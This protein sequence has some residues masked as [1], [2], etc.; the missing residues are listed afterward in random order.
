MKNYC[1]KHQLNHGAKYKSCYG[2]KEVKAKMPSKAMIKKASILGSIAQLKTFEKGCQILIL[3]EVLKDVEEFDTVNL[4]PFG[5][6]GGSML[7]KN[8]VDYLKNKIKG[9][10][11]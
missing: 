7:Q 5:S 10:R 6:A 1:I 8:M 11:K 3:Q 2:E 4:M 9:L